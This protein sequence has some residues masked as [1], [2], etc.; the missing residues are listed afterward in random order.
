MNKL[1][2]IIHREFIAKVR[3]K[4]FIVMTFFEPINYGGYGCFDLLF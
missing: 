4:S 2:L 1:T 3:N